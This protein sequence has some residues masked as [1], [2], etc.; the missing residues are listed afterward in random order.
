MTTPVIAANVQIP[1]Q[2]NSAIVADF[3]AHALRV[4]YVTRRDLERV[5]KSEWD[6]PGIYVLLTDDGSHTVYVGKAN[7]MRGRL[8]QHRSSPKLA[9]SRAVVIKRDTSHGFNSAEIGYLEGRVA[10]EIGAISGVTVIEGKRDQ[11]NTLP[12]HMLI[13]L[14]ELLESIMAA[15][16]LAG[17]D[18]F[19][20]ADVSE[21]PEPPTEQGRRRWNVADL[22]SQGLLRAGTDLYLSQGGRKATGRV[23]SSG[24]IV[25]DGVSYASPS[26]AAATALGTRSSNGWTTWH[27][28]SLTGL[29]LDALR[30]QLQRDSES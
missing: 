27:V 22:L 13:S 1:S 12:S 14:D 11:D 16:R 5:P 15:L 17:M 28:G 20:V 6:V 10:E 29:T 2:P 8:F 26:L 18:T 19:K 24:E 21:A 25:V 7:R 30:N 9:W 23:T 3:V 4:G